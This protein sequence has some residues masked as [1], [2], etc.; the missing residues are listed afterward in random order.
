MAWFEALTG[1]DP[2]AGSGSFEALLASLVGVAI[3]AIAAVLV[4]RRGR[5]TAR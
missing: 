4:S 2:D 3:I 1:I 5:R